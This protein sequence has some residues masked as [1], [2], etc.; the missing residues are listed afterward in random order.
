MS[1]HVSQLFDFTMIIYFS[2]DVLN[3]LNCDPLTLTN[4]LL[5]LNTRLH[6]SVVYK[7]SMQ[8]L[9]G[10]WLESSGITQQQFWDQTSCRWVEGSMRAL[11]APGL[12]PAHVVSDERLQKILRCLFDTS[13]TILWRVSVSTLCLRMS[14][15]GATVA[16]TKAVCVCER[17]KQ[18]QEGAG[19]HS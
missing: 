1:Q 18:R 2:C 19:R 15:L 7:E 3:E 9:S 8:Q 16:E 10:M 12:L 13:L 6:K 11:R 4:N 17:E 5:S 14:C